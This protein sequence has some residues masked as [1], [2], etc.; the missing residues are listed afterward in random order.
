MYKKCIDC[1][2]HK[3]VEDPD[4]YDS[5]NSDDEALV[6]TK[7]RREPDPKSRYQVDRLPYKPIDVGLRPYQKKNV[8]VPD[9]CP[10][11]TST[12]RNEKI[13]NILN[14]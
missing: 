14:N 2:F 12:I 6:C 8:D 1:P 10:I 5:W 13:E 4:P 9:W 11:S 3:V 7:V